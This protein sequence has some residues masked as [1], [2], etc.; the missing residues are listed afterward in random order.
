MTE[1]NGRQSEHDIDPLFLERWSPRSYTGES[2]SHDALMTILDAARWAPSASN[3]QPWRFI[4]G[5]RGS[6]A[7]DGLLR[8]LD[9]GNQAWAKDVSVLVF[10]ISDTLRRGPDGTS[11]ASRS[12]S[13]DAGAAW[14][15]LAMQATMSGYLAHG[16][17]G[18]DYERA[19]RELDI[20]ADYRIE[21]AIGIGR[22]TDLNTLQDEWRQREVPNSRKPLTSLIFEGRF[23]QV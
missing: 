6:E 21:A 20:P 17:G 8:L 9:D 14:A 13:F 18:L 12:H 16:M 19:Q 1:A 2:M 4:Y 23:K 15:M 22:L 5:H 7:F 10:V 11:R 3:Y